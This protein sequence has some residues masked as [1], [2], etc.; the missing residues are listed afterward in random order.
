M[1]PTRS[2]AATKPAGRSKHWWP[3]WLLAF[4]TEAVA[5]NGF[6]DTVADTFADTWQAALCKGQ[7]PTVQLAYRGAITE[8][9]GQICYH[10]AGYNETCL[11]P[12]GRWLTPATR[13]RLLTPG[14]VPSELLLGYTLLVRFTAVS[15]KVHAYPLT[16]SRC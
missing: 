14:Q 15:D 5:A 4:A 3:L 16:L 9:R 8:Y 11:S 13:L 1:W 12:A 2:V 7:P 6:A 10:Y